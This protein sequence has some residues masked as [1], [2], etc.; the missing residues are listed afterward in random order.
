MMQLGQGGHG[1][2]G[3]PPV[4]LTL[5]ESDDEDSSPKRRRADTRGKPY[6]KSKKNKLPAA[7][8]WDA[9]RSLLSEQKDDG[10][11]QPRARG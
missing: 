5:D 4:P 7:F 6:P 9:F 10:P 11:Q 1:G 2:K 8:D 3:G